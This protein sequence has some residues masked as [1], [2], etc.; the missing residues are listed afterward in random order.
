MSASTTLRYAAAL[1]PSLSPPDVL[2]CSAS[3]LNMPMMASLPSPP[4]ACLQRSVTAAALRPRNLTWTEVQMGRL[5]LSHSGNLCRI[6]GV[7][8]T[9]R[10]SLRTREQHGT[11]SLESMV[12]GRTLSRIMH[13]LRMDEDRWPH[14]LF[15][16]SLASS[17]AEDGRV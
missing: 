2:K 12:R 7:K 13:I 3:S 17:V 1:K 14:Q 8:L 9:D 4:A 16:C 15:D 6:V 5:Q 10:H 11:S